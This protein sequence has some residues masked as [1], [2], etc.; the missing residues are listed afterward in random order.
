MF[1]QHGEGEIKCVW[2]DNVEIIMIVVVA[3][4]DGCMDMKNPRS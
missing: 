3:V 2:R 1:G 4:I